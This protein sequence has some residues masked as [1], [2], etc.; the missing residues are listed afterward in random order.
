VAGGEVIGDDVV[1]VAMIGRL[2]HRAEVIAVNGDSCRYEPNRTIRCRRRC[3]RSP[4][5][6]RAVMVWCARA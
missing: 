2:V 3:S 1:A 4:G 5:G 6:G